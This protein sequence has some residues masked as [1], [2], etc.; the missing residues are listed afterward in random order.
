MARRRDRFPPQIGRNP[1]ACN[2]SPSSI[3]LIRGVWPLLGEAQL[4]VAGPGADPVEHGEDGRIALGPTAGH[5]ARIEASLV[6]SK[7]TIIG[8]IVRP[9]MH[10][11]SLMVFTKRSMALVCSLYSI[12]TGEAEIARQRRQISIPEDDVDGVGRHPAAAGARLIGRR[13]TR[14]VV[15]GRGVCGGGRRSLR[16]PRR[17]PMTTTMATPQAPT[18]TPTGRPPNRRHVSPQWSTAPP[19]R[20]LFPSLIATR[21]RGRDRR[22]LRRTRCVQSD[23]MAVCGAPT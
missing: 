17:L 4:V 20:P 6:G 3:G 7:V 5:Q 23:A 12:F 22:R 14:G 1:P 15:V 9:L 18:C 10:R 19:C 11:A 21:M 8:L 13:D 16:R 2:W